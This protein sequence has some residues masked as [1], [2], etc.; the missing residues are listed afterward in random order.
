M[1]EKDRRILA[2][3]QADGRMS[4]QELADRVNLSPSPCL[5]RVRQL[6]NSGVIQGYTALVDEQAV[7]LSVTAFVRVRLQV[8]S[9][10][11]V[12]TF[13]RAI[14]GMDAVLDCYVMTGSADFLLRVLV[15][16]L[17]DYEEFVRYQLHAVP[18]VASIDTS[19]AYGHVKR[20]TV[21]PRLKASD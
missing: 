13:E 12:N 14:A 20:A 4:N 3:L 18:Y 15:E 21:F 5:R 16:S 7:G 19:F 10:E 6:E 8:H 11:S 9:T 17:K 1:D 2:C